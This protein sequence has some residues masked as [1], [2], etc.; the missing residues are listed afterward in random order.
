MKNSQSIFVVSGVV[1][2]VGFRYY[3][4]REAQ[5]LAISGYA[6]N[7]NDGRVEV[8]AV[9]ES[10]QIEKLYQWLQVGPASATVDNVVKQRLEE[11]TKQDVCIGEFRIL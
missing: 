3:T 10:S 6:K 4:S 9:G 1:Q 7:L 8:L 5:K 11:G 2:C